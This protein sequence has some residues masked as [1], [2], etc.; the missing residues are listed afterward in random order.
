MSTSCCSRCQRF[1]FPRSAL[2]Q[3]LHCCCLIITQT[4]DITVTCRNVAGNVISDLH[5]GNIKM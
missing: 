4:E 3:H 2:E 5:G 1:T